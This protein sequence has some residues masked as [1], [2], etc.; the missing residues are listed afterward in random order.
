MRMIKW[1]N[2]FSVNVSSID[3]EHKRF[4]FILNKINAA[5]HI[6]DKPEKKY[7]IL[8]ETLN[9]M[10]LYALSHFKTEEK[11]MTMFDYPDYQQHKKEHKDFLITTVGF[12]ERVMNESYNH[13]VIMDDLFDYLNQW[14]AKHIKGSDKKYIECFS[15]NGIY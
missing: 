1:E 10:T 6:N 14:L 11:Y 9:E 3:E 2:K 4:I 15:K 5:S 13:V 8:S 12:C 7:E